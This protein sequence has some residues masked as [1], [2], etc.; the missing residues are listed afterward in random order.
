MARPGSSPQGE[1][2]RSSHEPAGW[3]S[4]PLAVQCVEGARAD[5]NQGPAGPGWAAHST[6]PVLSA[7]ECV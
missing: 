7:M 1:L 6:A 2:P 4:T 3:N 5:G